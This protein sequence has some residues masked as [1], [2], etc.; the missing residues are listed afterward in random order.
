MTNAL[1]RRG[2]ANRR[3]WSI[4]GFLLVMGVGALDGLTGYELAFSSFYLLP[5][6]VVTWFGGRRLGIVAS[7]ASAVCWLAADTLTGHPYSHPSLPYWNTLIRLSAFLVVALLIAALRTAHDH[8]M[9]LARTDDL[10]GAVNARFFSERI[11]MELVRAQRS[12][13][14]FTVAYLDLDNFKTVNDREGHGVGDAV[15]C[16]TVEHAR[17]RLRKTDVVARLGGDEF[18]FLLPETGPDAAQAAIPKV[19]RSLLEAMR[20]NGWPVTFSIGVLTCVEIPHTIDELI[21]QADEVMYAVKNSG[22][23][24]IRYSVARAAPLFEPLPSSAAA[25]RG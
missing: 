9:A 15:L 6:A 8:E 23:N 11:D 14:P 17:R 24:A 19:Q 3:L 16:T 13:R 2:E 12:G 1:L 4:V 22:K 5:I 18:A 7:L 10:T 20:S 25:R 21:R